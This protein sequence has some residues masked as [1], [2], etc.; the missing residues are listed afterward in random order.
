MTH[1]ELRKRGSTWRLGSIGCLTLVGTLALGGSVLPLRAQENDRNARE[2]RDFSDRD[3]T[4]AVENEIRADAGVSLN[5]IDVESEDG[6]VIL[7]GTVDSLV[8]RDRAVDAAERI[9]G[10]RSVENRLK[11]QG[12]DRSDDVIRRD[13]RNL[14]ESSRPAAAKNID[15]DVEDGHVTLRGRIDNWNT[16]RLVENYARDVRGVRSIENEIEVGPDQRQER[17]DNEIASAILSRFQNDAMLYDADIKAEVRNGRVQLSGE[18]ASAAARSQAIRNADVPGVVSI[19]ADE[20][21]VEPDQQRARTSSDRRRRVVRRSDEETAEG[22]EQALGYDPALGNDQVD[23]E[24]EDGVAYL[25]GTVDSLSAKR[26][27][28]RQARDIHGVYRVRNTLRVRP[29]VDQEDRQI[30]ERVANALGSD[31]YLDSDDLEVAVRNGRVTLTGD[32]DSQFERS[33]ATDIASRVQGVVAVSNRIDVDDD[34][35]DF[36]DEDERE[37][38]SDAEIREDIVDQLFWSPFVDH[39]QINVTVEDGVATLS[40]LVSTTSERNA[41]IENAKD[42]GA[43]RVRD[44]IKVEKY[45][46][47]D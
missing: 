4:R 37:Y 43:R 20:L 29:E 11:V 2:T 17:S 38:T 12:G 47:R 25:T 27:A 33:R 32:T 31:S 24:V 35:F 22:I 7:S 42:G 13:L 3:L 28:S 36:G 8:M 15:M 10:V 5:S 45:L 14:L 46:D 16:R 1:N 41:A 6:K 44:R 18:V 21:E 19:S 34:W 40:G 26:A 9:R 30:A 23:V 39:D